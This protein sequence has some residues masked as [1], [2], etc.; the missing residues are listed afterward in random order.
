MFL[1]QNSVYHVAYKKQYNT[2]S[3][4]LLLRA[5]HEG[6]AVKAKVKAAAACMG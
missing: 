5:W 3:S 6:T 4:R 1:Q 2:S